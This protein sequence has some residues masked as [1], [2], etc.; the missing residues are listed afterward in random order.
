[1]A[2]DE[3]MGD[4]SGICLYQRGGKRNGAANY[5]ISEGGG[6]RCGGKAVP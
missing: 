1:M 3:Q 6:T 5:C 2:D 4:A